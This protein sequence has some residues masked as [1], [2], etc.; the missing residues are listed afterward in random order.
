MNGAHLVG[1]GG[2]LDADALS[3]PRVSKSVSA[4]ARTLLGESVD[5]GSQCA[6]C[7]RTWADDVK[8][9]LYGLIEVYQAD[10]PRLL[11]ML[12]CSDCAAKSNLF[13]PLEGVVK[14]ISGNG[15]LRFLGFLTGGR[16]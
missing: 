16:A 6:G 5:G 9:Y 14:E 12:F 10:D 13:D 7:G 11:S 8:P 4:A 2:V 1:D 3:D 15:T